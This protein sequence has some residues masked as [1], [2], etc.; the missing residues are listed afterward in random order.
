M[1]DHE[2]FEHS[3]AVSEALVAH[4]R[5]ADDEA[6]SGLLREEGQAAADFVLKSLNSAS[7][8]E[9]MGYAD[10]W[11]SLFMGDRRSDRL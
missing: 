3:K 7:A 9:F 4:Y 2:L 10:G 11:S 1:T 6:V 5:G 8:V